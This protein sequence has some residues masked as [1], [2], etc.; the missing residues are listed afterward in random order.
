MRNLIVARW[1][2]LIPWNPHKYSRFSKELKR[3][4]QSN[5]LRE[6]SRKVFLKVL[7]FVLTNSLRFINMKFL[8]QFKISEMRLT[9]CTN[10]NS[11]RHMLKYLINT[12]N[13]TTAS[14]KLVRYSIRSLKR[15]VYRLEQL[16]KKKIISQ[17]LILKI[18]KIPMNI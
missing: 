15:Y 12:L 14:S 13:I 10:C 4:H 2:L 18:S 16:S 8:M 7:E 3:A 11:W 5:S 6:F 1:A 9:L 17:A